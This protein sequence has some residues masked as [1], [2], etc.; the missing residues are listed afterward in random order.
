MNHSVA[1]VYFKMSYTK[2]YQVSRY[3]RHD[4]RSETP[5]KI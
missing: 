4:D 1:R 5:D 3:A 2:F